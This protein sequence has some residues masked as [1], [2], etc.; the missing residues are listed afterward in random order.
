MIE[1]PE[2]VNRNRTEPGLRAESGPGS[3][4]GRE[5]IDDAVEDASLSG[6]GSRPQRSCVSGLTR[7]RQRREAATIASRAA[8][9]SDRTRLAAVSG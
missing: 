3:L 7:V 1:N 2:S 4:G 9:D 5:C 6:Q 8:A